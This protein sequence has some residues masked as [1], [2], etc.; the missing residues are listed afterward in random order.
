MYTSCYRSIHTHNLLSMVCVIPNGSYPL[1]VSNSLVNRVS[2]A[3][4]N[5]HKEMEMRP[6]ISPYFELSLDNRPVIH[7]IETMNFFKMR[8]SY[9]LLIHWFSMCQQQDLIHFLSQRCDC[10]TYNSFLHISIQREHQ[11]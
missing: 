6:R 8:G 10:K 11:Q 5:Y 2:T 9:L 3:N 1:Q 4:K 7:E